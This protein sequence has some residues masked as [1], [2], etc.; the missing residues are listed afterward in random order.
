VFVHVGQEVAAQA[1]LFRL[2]DRSLQAELKVRQ[3][4]VATTQA[5]LARLKQMPRPDELTASAARVGEARAYLKAQQADL[6][7]GQQLRK[8]DL[9]SPPEVE[10]LQQAVVAAQEQL[11][12]AQADDR[13]LRAGAWERDLAIAQAAVAE[14]Q[15]LVDQAKAELTRLTVGSPMAATVLQVNVKK[16]ERVTDMP[17]VVLGDTHALHLRVDIEEHQIARFHAGASARA[18]PRGQ[19]APSFSLRFVRVEPLVVPKV[20]LKG[21]SSERKDTRV[22]QV[23]YEFDPGKA[24]VH[25]GQ[26]MDVFIASEPIVEVSH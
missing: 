26:Q 10:R 22:L 2:D 16:G 12:R 5:Q 20:A 13:Q 6:E 3:A 17:P 9:L 15:S 21:E 14:A 19:P 25:V 8:R 1:P 23:I 7:R 24:P 4:R 11:A 18:L